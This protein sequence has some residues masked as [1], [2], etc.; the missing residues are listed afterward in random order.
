MPL[1][2]ASPS[3]WS[4]PGCTAETFSR[5][6]CSVSVAIASGTLYISKLPVQAVNLNNAVTRV[7]GTAKATGTHGWMCVLDDS[8]NVINTTAD[9]VDAS[10]TWGTPGAEQSLPFLAPY[11]QYLNQIKN[12]YLG[13]CVVAGTMPTV[14][15][16]PAISNGNTDLPYFCGTAGSGLTTP[17]VIGTKLTFAANGNQIW[18]YTT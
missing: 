16:G 13:I 14:V 1:I 10:T 6:L 17:P 18:G 12:W 3:P 8:G 5:E 7:A 2:P 11:Q 15:G 9:Q 4:R